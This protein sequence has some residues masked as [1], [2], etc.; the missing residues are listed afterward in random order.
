MTPP[1]PGSGMH[2]HR[3]LRTLVTVVEQQNGQ[4]LIEF[5]ISLGVLLTAIFTLIELCLVFYTWSTISECARE[6]TRYAIVRGST[7]ITAGT[8]GAGAS[9]TATA[10][11]I[12]TYVSSLGYPNAGGGTMT[13]DT[14]YSSD[15]ATF[16]TTGNN[17]PNNMVRVQITYH[18]PIKLPLVPKNALTLKAQSQ[19]T[20]LQ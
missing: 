12:N 1:A 4:T 3:K 11:S 7:C 6:G 2:C 15:G 16:T 17:S 14:T 20:I 18:F 5:A 10:S 8:S 9:C 13:V 19:M